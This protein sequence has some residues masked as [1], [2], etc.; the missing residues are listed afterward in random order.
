MKRNF[1]LFIGIIAAI[2]LGVNSFKRILAF[3]ETSKRVADSEAKLEVLKQ[4][5]EK[6]K[7]E[8][9]YK[10]SQEYKE[11]EI[12]NKLGLAKPNETVVILPDEGNKND[13][14]NSKKELA[15][16]KKWWKLF[17]QS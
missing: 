13:G 9:Q 7:Q 4:E 5:N 3:R 6:L 12:R 1:L 17:F 15:N 8:M 16:W 14:K 10:L 11:A 2:L